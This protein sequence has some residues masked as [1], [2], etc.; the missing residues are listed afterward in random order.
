VAAALPYEVDASAYLGDEVLAMVGE[1][2][3]DGG[4]VGEGGGYHH[5]SEHRDLQV[6]H[7]EM[8]GEDTDSLVEDRD[9]KAAHT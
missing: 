9:A 6:R 3:L 8:V 4:K 1:D 7:N 2:L 5:T